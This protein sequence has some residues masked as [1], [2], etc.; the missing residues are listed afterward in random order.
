MRKLI[1]FETANGMFSDDED[2]DML[3]SQ[4]VK[5]LPKFGI[6]FYPIPNTVDRL[7]YMI[8]T[9]K[10]SDDELIKYGDLE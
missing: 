9:E 7:A 3:V 8:S 10:L 2:L 6:F 5:Q 1:K 4:L